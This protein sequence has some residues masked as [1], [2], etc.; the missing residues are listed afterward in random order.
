[1]RMRLYVIALFLIAGCSNPDSGFMDKL[2]LRTLDNQPVTLPENE[3]T[4]FVINF[5]ATWCK[6][7]IREIPSLRKLNQ[8]FPDIQINVIFIS[9]EEGD[10]V[11]EFITDKELG[12]ES[13]LMPTSFET[14]GLLYLPTTFLISPEGEILLKEEGEREWDGEFMISRIQ[15]AIESN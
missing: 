9:N 10:H 3:E 4:Y 5:W 8:Q 15:D 12:I 2:D 7:C 11:R 1:M 14:Y 13:Y 6:P